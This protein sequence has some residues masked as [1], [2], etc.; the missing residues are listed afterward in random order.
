[1]SLENRLGIYWLKGVEM[2]SVVFIRDYIQLGF[3]GI[4]EPATLNTY[5]LPT[6]QNNKYTYSHGTKGYR[7][8]LCS[9]INK[10]VEKVILVENEGIKL[11]FEMNILLEISL[12]DEDYEGPEAAMFIR[13]DETVV[14]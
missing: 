8:E 13:G 4:Y 6:V 5:T 2:T 9:L 12:R 11:V 1:M 3:E 14:W 10:K 7:D